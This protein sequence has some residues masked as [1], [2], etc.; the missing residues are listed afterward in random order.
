MLLAI[1]ACAWTPTQSWEEAIVMYRS[2]EFQEIAPYRH[3]PI[4]GALYL[5]LAL[6][7]RVSATS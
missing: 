4:E 7:H 5:E 3:N 2:L 1:V 6:Q